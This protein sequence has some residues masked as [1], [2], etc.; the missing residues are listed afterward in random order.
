M[1]RGMDQAIEDGRQIE[2]AVEAVLELCEIAIGIF[3][4]VEGMVS[5]GDRCLQI[6]QHRVDVAELGVQDG[7]A[8]TAGFDGAVVSKLGCQSRLHAGQRIAVNHRFGMQGL[9]GPVL[10]PFFGEAHRLEAD[11]LRLAVHAGLDGGDE[12]DFVL[13]A[14]PGRAGPLAA[15][16][17]VVNL[18]TAGQH[19]PLFT[20][21]HHLHQLV[22]DFPGRWIRHA[23]VALQL[24]GRHIVLGLSEQVHGQKPGGQRQ[25]GRIEDRSGNHRGLMPATAALPVAALL[26]FEHA[27]ARVPALR[28]AKALGPARGFHRL[29]ALPLRAETPHEFSHRQP[30]LKLNL[31]HRHRR[32]HP[33]P[34]RC[35]DRQ[36]RLSL[37][38]NYV[39]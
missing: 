3:G 21:R 34:V 35:S 13:R 5:P 7:V 26:A 32:L 23:E 27:G 37:V 6:A 20:V 16:I 17:R 2:A 22:L 28:A 25:L 19:S 31:V 10:N 8:P 18:D 38:S 11:F 12:R 36:Q 1:G 39:S 4:E 33:D 29:L 24:Q 14:T 15:Q 9:I 30:S